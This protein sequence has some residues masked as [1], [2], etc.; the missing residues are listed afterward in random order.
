MRAACLSVITVAIATVAAAQDIKVYSELT[1]IDPFGEIVRADRGEPPR[2]IL[3]PAIPR[4]AYS[5]FRVV[6]Y[7]KP[8]TPYTLHAG[9]NPENAVGLD[10]YR[11][12]YV[13]S[14]AEW[15]PDRLERVNL[16]YDGVLGTPALPGQTAQT[17]LLDLHVDEKA[18]V[19]RIKVEAQVW[20]I[21]RW[22]EYPMEVRVVPTVVPDGTERR[23]A[24]PD[25][26]S[27]TD[28]VITAAYQSVV[29]PGS[30]KPSPI[31]EPTS[32]GIVARNALQDVRTARAAGILPSSLANTRSE[33]Q[34]W[35]VPYHSNPRGPEWY[36][37]TRDA[38]YRSRE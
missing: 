11:E 25:V 15:I 20:I 18:A 13:Q 30:N 24:L 5:T 14:G 31:L 4:N 10:V 29:C 28:A 37:R 32:R 8:G 21:D 19:R 12:I 16:P 36:L 33:T 35:C 27:P 1:R 23:S 34:P 22:L 2:E 3:S 38:I 17:F 6:I 7:G 9:Q 26:S